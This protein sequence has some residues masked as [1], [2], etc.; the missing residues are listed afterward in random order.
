MKRTALISLTWCLLIA[1]Y[2]TSVCAQPGGGRGPRGFGG[3]GID[4]LL[5]N[6]NV[7]KH[8]GLTE[9]QTKKIQTIT[10]ES[11]R[12]FRE[13]MEAGGQQDGPPSREAMDRMR[14]EMEK[15]REAT[16]A[17]LK[18]ALTPEQRETLKVLRFQLG[19][20][21]EAREL[22]VGLLEALQLTAEQVEKIKALEAE[23]QAETQKLM[24]QVNWN[25]QEERE[26]RGPEIWGKADELRQQYAGKIK[27]L[28]TP[29]QVQLAGKLTN[30]GKAVKE[31]IG[32]LN[33]GGRGGRGG[34]ASPSQPRQR[35]AFPQER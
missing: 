28:L 30:E 18:E 26:N 15:Q 7:Q 22:N 4:S 16:D 6:A 25:N 17:K 34:Q 14:V 10:E 19:D 21:L 29:E 3:G 2:A 13:R 23:R 11:R 35:R 32:P 12:S 33:Q 1:I 8:L 5:G 31:K 20:G 27:A 24:A 9:D